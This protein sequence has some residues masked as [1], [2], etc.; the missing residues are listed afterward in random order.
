MQQKKPINRGE[1]SGHVVRL[2]YAIE[3]YQ[4]YLE[5]QISIERISGLKIICDYA[6]GAASQIGPNLLSAI[7][8][9]ASALNNT[10]DGLNINR[11]AGVMAP[12]QFEE[13]LKNNPCDFGISLDG[14]AD[15]VMI[16][17]RNQYCDPNYILLMLY[18][19]YR[20]KN[21]YQAGLVGTIMHNQGIVRYCHQENIPLV[22][23][24]V[25]DRNLIHTS[26][27]YNYLLAGEPSGH[28]I[29]MD[30]LPTADGLLIAL[31]LIEHLSQK[32]DNMRD[33]NWY[34]SHV[35]LDLA[36][37]CNIKHHSPKKLVMQDALQAQISS[38]RAEHPDLKITVRG[39][40][41][42]PLVRIHIEGQHALEELQ[43]VSNEVKY[44]I[45]H[46]PLWD[47]ESFSSHIE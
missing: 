43:S 9:N 18:D 38:I 1:V 41:T 17:H 5:S 16:Y 14:D 33:L 13:Y 7:H 23:T 8:A 39:S 21:N 34:K 27:Q 45:E 11:N 10:P 46:S 42:E 2:S 25:G 12:T 24:D 40:G 44:A 20:Q 22:L 26:R 28:Y 30:R 37:S 35:P 3:E 19:I 15:R 32:N 31:L 29:C 36:Y 6:H 47:K 4:R